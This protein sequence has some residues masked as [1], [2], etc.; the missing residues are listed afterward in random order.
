MRPWAF[1]ALCLAVP[2]FAEADGRRLE[3]AD[4]RRLRAVGDVAAL[5]RRDARRLHGQH[6]RRPGPARPPA[7]RD[8]AGGRAQ[9]AAGRH[10]ERPRRRSG[11]PTAG[12]SRSAAPR[13][14]GA[15]SWS[16]GPTGRGLRFLAEMRGHQQPAHV[17][18]PRASPGRPTGKRIAFVSATP[19]PE[20]AA[21]ERRPDGD[22]ALP[23]QA[24]RRRRDDPLQR[25][26][27]PPHLHRGRGRRRGARRSPRATYEEHSI[28]W[29][30][31]G[32]EIAV[33][34]ATASRIPTSSTTR[35]SSR[36]AWPTAPSAAS[37]PP[38][39]PSTS[40]GG[41]RTAGASRSWARGAA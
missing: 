33:R 30:P 13:T 5:P 23:L 1:F 25:Q 28:D 14:A 38:R 35:T 12:W 21:A 27:P 37:P 2:A 29:S 24:R 3:S 40:R 31:D 36:C 17:R 15:G 20:T 32:R 6:V 18:R 11:R 7:L 39:A 10:G 4:Y 9:R 41:R 19:G 16:R 34:V 22:H 8:D 26:P